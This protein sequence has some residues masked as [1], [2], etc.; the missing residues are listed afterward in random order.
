MD[1]RIRL[2]DALKK[3]TQDQDKICT[4]QETVQ[5]FMKKLENVPLRILGE[6][7][8][9]DNGRLDIP[10]YVSKC[11]PDA[12]RLTG[13]K[14][15]MGKGA[16]PDQAK[17][18]A[19]MELAERFSFFSFRSQPQNFKSATFSSVS[20]NPISLEMIASSVHDQKTDLKTVGQ[21]M[22]LLPLTWTWG[23]NLALEQ[24]VQVPF[25]WF[26]AINE[27]NGPSAGNCVEEALSQ[28]ICEVV[29]R[30]VSSLISR[31][32]SSV[33][34]IDPASSN[35]PMV[36]Q[37]LAKYKKAGI[38]LYLSDFS[39][40]TGIPT[41]GALAWD[42]T[43]FPEKSEIVWTAGT[44]PDPQKA[45]SRA[46]TETAQLGGDFNSGA[47]FVASGLPKFTHIDQAR[48]ITHPPQTVAIGDLPD[49]SDANIRVEVEK[50]VATLAARQMQP[51]VIDVTHPQLQVPAFYTIIPGAHFR[52]RADGADVGMFAAKIVTENHPTGPA[53][54]ILQKM[55]QIIPDRYYLEFYA[56]NCLLTEQRIDAAQACFDRALRLQPPDENR[57]SIMVY[58][59][60][61]HK[62]RERFAEALDILTT[63]E[64]IDAERPELYNL[65]GFCEF[66]LSRHEQAIASFKRALD[67]DPSEAI[68]W[69]NI[70]SNYRDMGQ[71]EKAIEYYRIALSQ[72]PSL[73]FARE[74]LLRLAGSSN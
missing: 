70:A 2:K 27:F 34:A 17:A 5:N 15:Q 55:Q 24:P 42:P 74:N 60:I 62:E 11:G 63:A 51:I 66:K 6:V 58:S 46:L 38:E 3:Y 73:D 35:D 36:Q 25:N 52:E 53:L 71:T 9:I 19:V 56:G 16:T 54:K 8:R 18:S 61:C 26:F 44:T 41:V 20:K 39:L 13:T 21:L 72:D 68:N 29:E 7:L 48:Y 14:K 31:G 59:A 30:H 57:V 4:P 45:L 67:L 28:G 64:K 40:D 32:R 22:D 12:A 10:V 65:K 50:L 23:Y 37:M 47:N 69:A 43:T 1:T 33:P 49:L